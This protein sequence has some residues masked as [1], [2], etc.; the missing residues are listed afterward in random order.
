MRK[1]ASLPWLQPFFTFSYYAYKRFF[2]DPFHALTRKHPQLFR[3]GHILDVGAN[4]GYTTSVF[5]KVLESPYK[6]YAFEPDISNFQ[7]LSLNAQ[8]R[9]WHDSVALMRHAVGDTDGEARLWL[10]SENAADHRILTPEFERSLGN[11]V[12]SSTIPIVR[13]DS[14]CQRQ[15]H[16]GADKICKNRCA[17][18]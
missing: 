13:L 8:R 6:I 10:N 18:L 17:G 1:L 11:V 7:L 15:S 14:F 4:I 3:G 9:G 5:L 12:S 2:E 16:Q